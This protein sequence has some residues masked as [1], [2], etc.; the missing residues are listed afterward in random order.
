MRTIGL[1][2]VAAAVLAACGGG[3]SGSSDGGGNTTPALTGVVVDGLIEGASVC[4]DLNV[5]LSCDAGEPTTTTKA[6]GSYSLSL[7]GLSTAQI[8]GA[9][10][11][12]T[13]PDTA[14]DAD[15]GG[16]TL[17]EAGKSAFNLKGPA[18][19]FVSEDGKTISSAVVSPLT[20]LV[21]HEM[22][23]GS[24][25]SADAAAIA[26]VAN[27]GLPQDTD[28]KQNFIGK[29]DAPG[30]ELQK[31][32]RQIAGALG[33]L[34]KLAATAASGN[35][36]VALLGALD[37]LKTNV[38]ALV[39]AADAANTSATTPAEQF[40]AVKLALTTTAPAPVAAT[41]ATN[42][43][44][45]ISSSAT[46]DAVA[47][48]FAKVIEG[49]FYSA[50]CIES[51]S[52]A[53]TR[54]CHKWKLNHTKATGAGKWESVRYYNKPLETAGW[55]QSVPDAKYNE[56]ELVDGKG[57]VSTNV[58]PKTGSYSADSTGLVTVTPDT[59]GT[60]FKNR[61][62]VK[63]V[64]GKAI[65][66]LGKVGNLASVT[67]FLSDTA[68]ATVLPPG[69]KLIAESEVY[70][71]DEYRLNYSTVKNYSSCS[72]S[73]CDGTVLTSLDA[74]LALYATQ[75]TFNGQHGRWFWYGSNWNYDAPS[76][77]G[78]FDTGGSATGGTM[79]VWKQNSSYQWVKQD[80]KASYDIKTVF[81]QQVLI[82]NPPAS[83]LNART[84][85]S[86]EELFAVR[87]GK[88]YSGEYA[89]AA[90]R[91]KFSSHGNWNAIAMDALI[92]ASGGTG[93]PK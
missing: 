27:I 76:A 65:N 49:G 38:K 55:T 80:E 60:S 87:D 6:D 88:L 58:N 86:S 44:A 69:S 4:L 62:S 40:A 5:S 45:F 74:L 78:T 53:S 56:Y 17:A 43:Q 11:L 82:I 77:V 23:S 29:S 90:T 50:S 28:L 32:A 39:A 10:I 3:G 24:G 71:T 22:M 89:S 48:D 12:T 61:M 57:W 20:T 37:Y 8:R 21:S 51:T 7:D 14:K 81:G 73:P 19:T 16:K 64:S 52:T 15:D 1:S 59:T 34:K 75:T 68:K 93:L 83:V 84:T 79:S 47:T 85:A 91:A 72:S 30:K 26:V 46:V 54:I 66:E 41:L 63:D 92:K 36:R 13:V 67:P 2:V 33:E 70:T 31:R 35:D 18:E 25:K 42:A 9:H